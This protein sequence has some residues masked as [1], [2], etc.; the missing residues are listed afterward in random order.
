MNVNQSSQ[1][2]VVAC[3]S[4]G[5]STTKNKQTVPPITI[6]KIWFDYNVKGLSIKDVVVT[7]YVAKGYFDSHDEYTH[8]AYFDRI[9]F[10]GKNITPLIAMPL[11]DFT[12]AN[13]CFLSYLDQVVDAKDYLFKNQ[14]YSSLVEADVSTRTIGAIITIG[15]EKYNLQIVYDYAKVKDYVEHE[16]KAISDIL[17]NDV[18]LKSALPSDIY[19]EMY[20]QAYDI[21][22]CGSDVDYLI[23]EIH[24][25]GV[26]KWLFK[27]EKNS[28][29]SKS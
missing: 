26:I 18:S 10:C 19:N 17:I 13:G 15:T 24:E 27:K 23:N 28:N 5:V 6:R 1:K 8:R 9:E 25:A 12:Q 20:E 2:S 4:S 3:N 21:L 16:F 22:S 29:N 11:G 7:G 14:Y